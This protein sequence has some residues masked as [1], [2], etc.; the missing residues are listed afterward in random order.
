MESTP[1]N[2]VP[3]TPMAPSAPAKVSGV[4]DVFM[5]IAMML[6]LATAISSLVLLI[7]TLVN[8]VLPDQFNCGCNFTSDITMHVATLI[9]AAGFFFYLTWKMRKEE[10]TMPFHHAS[11]FH[12]VMVYLALFLSGLTIAYSVID[13]LQ[14]TL[15][16]GFTFAVVVKLALLVLI[17]G[18]VFAYYLSDI[19]LGGDLSHSKLAKASWWV[20]IAVMLGATIGA[21]IV[22]GSPSFQ[23]GKRFDE[24]RLSSLQSIK[25]DIDS[26][27]AGSDMTLPSK[28][29]D[30]YS[31]EYMNELLDPEY[32]QPYEYTV[33][34]PGT[35][36]LCATFSTSSDDYAV[37]LSKVYGGNA[38]NTVDPWAHP[39]GHTCFHETVETSSDSSYGNDN[40]M[41][42]GIPSDSTSSPMDMMSGSS[43]TQS[44]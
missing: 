7:E 29:S 19:K 33:T 11:K 41:D 9:V 20:I 12:Q 36:D 37:K 26:T 13:I 23:K 30:M 5:N 3:P 39:A 17:F 32:N 42:T 43:N 27:F 14:S 10:A 40:S 4:R 44:N 15:Y 38:K 6:S 8:T 16:Y 24:M 21:F 1:V 34:G 18:S 28:L 25:S 31:P 2:P 22:V 35:Y